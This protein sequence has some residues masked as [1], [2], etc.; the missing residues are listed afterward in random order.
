MCPGHAAHAPS[1]DLVQG[2]S[3]CELF[4]GFVCSS[5]FLADRMSGERG[6]VPLRQCCSTKDAFPSFQVEWINV[7]T[8]DSP[9]QF[10]ANSQKSSLPNTS[11]IAVEDVDKEKI[12]DYD[13]LIF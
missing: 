5:V 3:E 1:T 10:Q 6:T 9:V 2:E 11:P 4:G 8:Q 13:I 7:K 12:V